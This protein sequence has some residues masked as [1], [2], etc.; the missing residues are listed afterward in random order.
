MGLA[1]AKA[2]NLM[3]DDAIAR[4]LELLEM[5]CGALLEYFNELENP[6]VYFIFFWTS[7]SLILFYYSQSHNPAVIEA[8]SSI[9]YAAPLVDCK[10]TYTAA[11]QI[12]HHLLNLIYRAGRAQD[13]SY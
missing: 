2:Q 3:Q 4:V 8:A 1:R 6:F 10:G 13:N 9:M 5:H 11:S 7:L 12:M